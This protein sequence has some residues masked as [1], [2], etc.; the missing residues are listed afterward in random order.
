[1]DLDKLPF[2]VTSIRVIKEVSFYSTD[3]YLDDLYNL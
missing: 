1:M 3:S 2:L